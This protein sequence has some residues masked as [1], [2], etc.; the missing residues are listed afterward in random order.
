MAKPK[1]PNK[2]MLEPAIV[3]GLEE[4]LT[5][6]SRGRPQHVDMWIAIKRSSSGLVWEREF[7]SLAER[8]NAKC[9]QA[10]ELQVIPF[11][12]QRGWIVARGVNHKAVAP[13]EVE[14]L[15]RTLVAEVN[16][17]LSLSPVAST[18]TPRK[19]DDSWTGRVRTLVSDGGAISRVL[20]LAPRRST[21]VDI[22][23][24]R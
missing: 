17:R 1:T 5:V 12:E 20:S 13:A 8:E 11:T 2:I 6:P 15:V 7:I 9:S 21:G 24:N 19:A 22:A 23:S 16:A 4:Q 14:E 10:G 18:P 3:V